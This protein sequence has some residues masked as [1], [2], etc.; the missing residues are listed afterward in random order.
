M[1][2]LIVEMMFCICSGD[3]IITFI[4]LLPKCTMKMPAQKKIKTK[5][6]M[7]DCY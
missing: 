4:E 1:N 6:F 7:L 2:L 5:T 3:K